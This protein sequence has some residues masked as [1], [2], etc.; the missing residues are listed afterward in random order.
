[1]DPLRFMVLIGLGQTENKVLALLVLYT[2]RPA[3]ATELHPRC[4]YTP[5]STASRQKAF[6]NW[7]RTIFAAHQR[8]TPD[9]ESR[10]WLDE[11]L[12]GMRGK[13]DNC[14]HQFW[15]V[16]SFVAEAK[17]WIPSHMQPAVNCAMKAVYFQEWVTN[18]LAVRAVGMVGPPFRV[19]SL[20]T[21]HRW[22]ER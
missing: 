9:E 10:A 22:I 11:Q 19:Q 13:R 1:M 8:R 21:C 15:R 4:W 20:R 2:T 18:Q 14:G 5:V 6:K 12:E 17:A 3:P 16:D 7:C